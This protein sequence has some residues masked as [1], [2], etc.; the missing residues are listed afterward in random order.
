MQE[1]ILDIQKLSTIAESQPHTDYYMA[2]LF[3]GI[4]FSMFTPLLLLCS[5]HYKILFV[6]R[7]F[8]PKLFGYDIPGKIERLNVTY[9]PCQHA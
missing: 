8:I 1:W 4:I 2:Y 5:Y 6:L 9:F 7:T 3:G